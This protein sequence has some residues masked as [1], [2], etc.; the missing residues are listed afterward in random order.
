MVKMPS[1][2]LG[3]LPARVAWNE[4]NPYCSTLFWLPIKEAVAVPPEHEIPARLSG[5]GSFRSGRSAL[6]GPAVSAGDKLVDPLADSEAIT[7]P[8]FCPAL[9]VTSCKLL[10]PKSPGVGGEPFLAISPK[11]SLVFE[12]LSSATTT[13]SGSTLTTP[14]VW[15]GVPVFE[16]GLVSRLKVWVEVVVV[17]SRIGLVHGLGFCEQVWL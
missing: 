16:P 7:L 10:P 14:P 8:P 13:L 4:V 9:K 5:A 2:P 12:V 1:K 17:E 11:K 6:K 15:L 3:V